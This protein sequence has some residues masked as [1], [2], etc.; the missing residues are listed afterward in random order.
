MFVS[1][2]AVGKRKSYQAWKMHHLV[3]DEFCVLDVQVRYWLLSRSNLKKEGLIV[4]HDL[5][6]QTVMV[7]RAW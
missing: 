1:A 2:I 4:A 3:Y 5:R 7:R 6:V